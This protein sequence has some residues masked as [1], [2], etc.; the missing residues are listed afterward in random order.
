MGQRAALLPYATQYLE[1]NPDDL[2]GLAALLGHSSLE[3]MMIYTEP[4][5]EQLLTRMERMERGSRQ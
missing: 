1:A 2:R 4:T 3:T 5:T